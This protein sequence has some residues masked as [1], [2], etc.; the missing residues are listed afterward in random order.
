VF[1]VRPLEPI[2]RARSLAHARVEDGEQRR[3]E[4]LLPIARLEL[5]RERGGF[6][7]PA[8]ARQRIAQRGDERRIAPL[9]LDRLF[10]AR[11][12]RGPVAL[13]LQRLPEDEEGR[14][15]AGVELERLFVLPDRGIPVAVVVI[16]GREIDPQQ[17]RERVDADS[18]SATSSIGLL[19]LAAELPLV[20]EQAR[21]L[22]D[23]RIQRDH[24][25][26]LALPASQSHSSRSFVAAS[27]M[28]ASASPSSRPTARSADVRAIG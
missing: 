11:D 5:A 15:E 17:R 1:L 22:R 3:V 28:C 4:R 7:S 2:E 23:A 6:L 19:G 8:G 13:A 16:R 9:G 12:G 21:R 14:D 25:F 10:A 24:A 18:P 20:T 27:D 26:E